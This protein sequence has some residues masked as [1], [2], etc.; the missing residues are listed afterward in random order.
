[1]S[2]Y[3]QQVLEWQLDVSLNKQLSKQV[4]NFYKRE[5]IAKWSLLKFVKDCKQ[6]V[7]TL[8]WKRSTHE[9]K[10]SRNLDSIVGS[11]FWKASLILVWRKS[12]TNCFRIFTNEKTFNN[13][14]CTNLYKIVDRLLFILALEKKSP[15]NCFLISIKEKTWKKLWL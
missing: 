7:K 8:F 3:I 14:I 9:K 5:N 13:W 1:M 12:N 4:L 6:I 10:W 11:S 15:T 2:I